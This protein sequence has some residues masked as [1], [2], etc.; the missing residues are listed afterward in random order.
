MSAPH[1]EPIVWIIDSE[2]W[3]RAGLRAELIERGCEAIGFTAIVEAV[4]TLQFLAGPK[5]HVIVLELREQDLGR[6]LLSALA[7]TGIP[8]VVLGGAMELNEPV[9]REF[10]WAAVIKRPFTLGA[11]TDKVIELARR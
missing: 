11:V 4:I 9:I 5:P 8:I 1:A 10:D 7:G 2:H 3:P 6:E